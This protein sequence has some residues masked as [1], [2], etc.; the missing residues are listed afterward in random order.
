M[1]TI[2]GIVQRGKKHGAEL[3]YR[4]ANIPLSDTTL[5]GVFAGCVRFDG[6]SYDAAL[7]ADPSRGLFEAHLLDF[8]GALYGKM[9]TVEIGEKIRDVR[10]FKDDAEART[11]IKDDIARIRE[12][13]AK[14]R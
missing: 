1:Q 7:F 13:G 8:A 10:R 5:S 2:R 12:Y 9:I 4:T 6:H 14:H 3:G 11:T